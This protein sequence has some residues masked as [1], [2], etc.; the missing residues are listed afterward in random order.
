[1]KKWIALLLTAALLTCCSAALAQVDMSSLENNDLYRVDVAQDGGHAF[2]SMNIVDEALAFSHKYSLSAY[3]SLAYSD[4]LITGYKTENANAVWRIWFEYNAEKS[5]NIHSI[6][7]TFGGKDYTFTDL[8]GANTG[9]PYADHVWETPCIV[10]GAANFDFWFDFIVACETLEDKKEI[11]NWQIPV[12]L[13]GDE[14]V[15]AAMGG[16]SALSIYLCGEEMASLIGVEGLFQ[17]NGTPLAVPETP[18]TAEAE[19]PATAEA[20]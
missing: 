17:M 13:H 15:E 2:V 1:M 14:D 10:L 3:P 4:I 18:A 12:V 19:V 20:E 11:M 9:M 16:L 7:I 5:L 6:T 8:S